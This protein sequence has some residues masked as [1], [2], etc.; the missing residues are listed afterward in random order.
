[1]EL[2]IKICGITSLKDAKLAA[3]F[4]ANAL[5]FMMY[6]HSSRKIDKNNAARII[7]TLPEEIT[8]V[9]VFVNS[10]FEYVESCLKVSPKIIPQFHGTE[11]PEFCSS[12]GRDFI[13]AIR[14]TKEIDLP[15]SFRRYSK[16]WMMLLD[17]FHKDSY[18]GS[19]VVFDWDLLLGK[20]LNKPY[21]LCGGLNPDNVERALSIVPCAGLDVSSGVES[22]PG[23]KDSVKVK[24]FIKIARNSSG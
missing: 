7:K 24:K 15:L 17:S 19:G 20:K 16:S 21:L 1:M 22:S 9:M 8:P 12:F 18:G 13:K 3:S 10:N 11:S 4:G 23:K 5:G 2:F 14:V 6:Q